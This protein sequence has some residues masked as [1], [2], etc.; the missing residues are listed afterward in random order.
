MRS[1]FMVGNILCLPCTCYAARL[2]S[3]LPPHFRWPLS[4]SILIQ[5]SCTHCRATLPPAHTKSALCCP[6]AVSCTHC[7]CWP[8][9]ARTHHA[10]AYYIHMRALSSC[11]FSSAHWT[12]PVCLSLCAHFLAARMRVAQ[13]HMVT[14]LPLPSAFRHDFWDWLVWEV[15]S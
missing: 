8:F 2:P 7:C 12:L 9:A 5:H 3:F 6:A 13:Q 11:T 10:C 4:S 14:V 15:C 1:I